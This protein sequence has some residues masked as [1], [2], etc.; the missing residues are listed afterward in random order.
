MLLASSAQAD[1]P[2]AE[3]IA[4]DLVT[5]NGTGCF[6]NV[7]AAMW[8]DNTGLSVSYSA[9]TATVG[10]GAGPFDFRKNCNLNLLIHVPPGFT[11]AIAAVDQSGF[12]SLAAGASG[13]VRMRLFFQGGPFP[14]FVDHSLTGPFNDDW[15]F[16]DTVDPAALVF[17]PCDT[18]PHLNIATE[19]RATLGTSDPATTTS[20]MA[21]DGVDTLPHAYH[22]VWKHC[23]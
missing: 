19:V 9:Y 21:M 12:A 17:A 13:V 23:G 18:Q 3:R 16:T 5:M 10:V 2:P 7:Q 22:L 1:P 20:F 6:G 15:W 4:I 14:P 11:F 8:P